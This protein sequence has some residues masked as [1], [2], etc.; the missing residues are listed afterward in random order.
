MDD[1]RRTCDMQRKLKGPHAR[2]KK[3][4]NPVHPGF[5]LVTP[6]ILIAVA[7][8]WPNLSW[9]WDSA[10]AAQSTQATDTPEQN[11]LQQLTTMKQDM[12]E[13]KTLLKKLVTRV[14]EL[15]ETA[16]AIVHIENVTRTVETQAATMQNLNTLVEKIDG[17]AKIA[18]VEVLTTRVDALEREKTE[19]VKK[20]EKTEQ[21]TVLTTRVDALE[22]EKTEQVKKEKEKTEQVTVLTTRVDALE[23]EKTEQVKKEKEKTEQVTVLTTRVDALEREKTE[24]VKKEEKTEQVTVLTTRVDALEREKTEQVKKEKEKTEQ[25]TVLTT[26]VD[27]LEKEKTEQVKKE[28]VTGLTTRVTTL[29]AAASRVAF[30]AM[31]KDNNEFK[32]GEKVIFSEVWTNVGDDYD[33]STGIFKARIG[34]LYFFT[35]TIHTHGGDIELHVYK[36]E[37]Q[38]TYMYNPTKGYHGSETNSLVMQLKIGDIVYVKADDYRVKSNTLQSMFS[39]F[40]IH[41][42]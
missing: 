14:D 3:P 16:A 1:H 18:Q 34:G 24:Q 8:A 5:F 17:V 10:A 36:N 40:L 15:D 37:E 28:Q 38:M 4:Q 2:K 20:E 22:R 13:L 42:M 11:L 25:V 33:E 41:R 7:T 32:S 9:P 12:D 21:V 26:R 31:I 19:Q 6:L 30:S 27:A 29:E 23:R 35:V 39:G